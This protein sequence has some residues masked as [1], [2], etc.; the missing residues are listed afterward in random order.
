MRNPKHSFFFYVKCFTWM[1]K[2]N[3]PP[4]G[5]FVLSSVSPTE[6]GFVRVLHSIFS[7][8]MT[9]LFWTGLRCSCWNHSSSLGVTALNAPNYHRD[10]FWLSP[11]TSVP[12][13]SSTP[14]VSFPFR[15]PSSCLTVSVD[16]RIYHM[17]SS[18]PRQPQLCLLHLPRV[19]CLSGT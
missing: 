1:N 16:E 9:A 10:R 17:P 11:P 14:S 13:I 2:T 12:F 8:T 3:K 18:A 6:M 7:G 19:T 5:W 15:A 4:I